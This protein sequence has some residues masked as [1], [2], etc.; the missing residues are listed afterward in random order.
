MLKKLTVNKN[1]IMQQLFGF[2]INRLSAKHFH[3]PQHLA[4]TKNLHFD[5]SLVITEAISR[6]SW[7][8]LHPRSGSRCQGGREEDARRQMETCHWLALLTGPLSVG[9]HAQTLLSS[10]SVLEQERKLFIEQCFN[11]SPI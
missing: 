2:G 4:S 11:F 5:A 7:P 1:N 8:F 6:S 3:F 9:S 10:L